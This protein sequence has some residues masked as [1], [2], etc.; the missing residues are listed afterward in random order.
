M[1]A[2]H[3]IASLGY[4]GAPPSVEIDWGERDQRR[5]YVV[6]AEVNALRWVRPGEVALAASTSLPC[7]TCMLEIVSYGIRR[8]AFRDHL[9]YQVYDRTL[10]ER[11]ALVGGVTVV[12]MPRRETAT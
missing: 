11:I 2:D 5:G 4:N 9:D 1:R 7:A 12:H 6:H 8:V 10:I 3:S